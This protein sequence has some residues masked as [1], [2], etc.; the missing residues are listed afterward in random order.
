MPSQWCWLKHT[1][2]VLEG[3]KREGRIKKNE[4]MGR[5]GRLPGETEDL[6]YLSHLDSQKSGGSRMCNSGKKKKYCRVCCG[7]F[8]MY[9]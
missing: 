3:R 9:G 7:G 1:S 2:S 6:G 8:E 5:T 4:D